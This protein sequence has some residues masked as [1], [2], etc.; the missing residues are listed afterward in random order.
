MPKRFNE[1]EK[2]WKMQN[3]IDFTKTGGLSGNQK[4]TI[5]FILTNYSLNLLFI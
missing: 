4:N 1:Y 5:T 3:S 2:V